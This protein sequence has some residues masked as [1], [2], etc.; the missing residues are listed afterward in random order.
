[1][2]GANIVD[3]PG[4]KPER[5]E[6]RDKPLLCSRCAGKVYRGPRA[7]RLVPPEDFDRLYRKYMG[8]VNAGKILEATEAVRM[9]QTKKARLRWVNVTPEEKAA[10]IARLHAQRDAHFARERSRREERKRQAEAALDQ[11]DP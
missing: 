4:L 8:L 10:F 2:C 6:R 3:M 1:V 9:A 7:K 5:R 11:T